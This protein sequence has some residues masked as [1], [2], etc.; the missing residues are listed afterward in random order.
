M[1][2]ES[3]TKTEEQTKEERELKL[4]ENEVKSQWPLAQEAVKN[5]NKKYNYQ[6]RLAGFRRAKNGAIA[7][8]S[9]NVPFFGMFTP[10]KGF[11]IISLKGDTI[12]NFYREHI[13]TYETYNIHHAF[14]YQ[15]NSYVL[16]AYLDET[17]KDFKL[18]DR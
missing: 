17:D 11:F 13:E 10:Q 12:T 5:L 6:N 9:E 2:P 1:E 15:E 8:T 3:Q 14:D 7:H 18:F 16:K 4:I